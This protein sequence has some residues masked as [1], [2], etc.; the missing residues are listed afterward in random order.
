M[1]TVPRGLNIT[2]RRPN[3]V[4]EHP[5]TFSSYTLGKVRDITGV[6]HET[7]AVDSASMCAR[8]TCCTSVSWVYRE[9]INSVAASTVTTCLS[10]LGASP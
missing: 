3:R 10:C 7:K 4:L 5:Y 2:R 9:P 6:V 8:Q 1:S